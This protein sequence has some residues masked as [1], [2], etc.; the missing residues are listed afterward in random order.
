MMMADLMATCEADAPLTVSLCP[1]TAALKDRTRSVEE[2]P[3]TQLS[4]MIDTG[5]EVLKEELESRF[6]I[7]RPSN[8]RL[9]QCYVQAEAN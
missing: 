2:R 7:A 8:T 6:F 9:V 1:P 3:G 5:R 4:T